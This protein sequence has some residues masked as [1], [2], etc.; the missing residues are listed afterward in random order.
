MLW[1]AQ[2]EELALADGRMEYIRFGTGKRVLVMLPGL[3]ESL[4]SMKGTAVP[5]AAMYR[6]FASGF[7]VYVFGRKEPLVQGA[8]VRGMAR[9]QAAA[10]DLL[11]IEKA[12]VFGVSMGGMI[13]QWL[14]VDFPEKV[15]HLVL[16]VT[17]AEP[18]PILRESIGEWVELAKAADHTEFMRSNLRRIYSAD[19]CRKNM[20]MAPILGRLTRPKSYDRFFIQADACLKH[21][22]TEALHGIRAK[23]LVIGGGQDKSLGGE[24]SRQIAAAIPGAELKMYPQWG[25]G[26][27]EE[28]KGFNR[29]VLDF[30]LDAG[31]M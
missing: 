25:H 5:V 2:F 8:S 7:T 13:A 16:T 12:D 15:G 14:A 3:G 18:N 28:E 27:Y 29:R 11:G 10:M 19:Y 21:D 17:S 31:E 30:L 23:T 20:W 6:A 22:A 26:L 9:D 4:R 24:A 1:N